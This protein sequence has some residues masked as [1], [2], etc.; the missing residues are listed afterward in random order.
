MKI[1]NEKWK[2][3]TKTRKEQLKSKNQNHS[4]NES[5]LQ[6]K[7]LKIKVIKAKGPPIKI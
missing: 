3:T 2:G 4:K 5:K 6:Q 7:N 1:R